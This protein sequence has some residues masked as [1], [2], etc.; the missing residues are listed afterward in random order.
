MIHKI[1]KCRNPLDELIALETVPSVKSKDIDELN[2]SCHNTLVGKV[3][4]I[5]KEEN[6][7]VEKIEDDKAE[8]LVSHSLKIEVMNIPEKS[9]N[10]VEIEV[11]SQVIQIEGKSIDDIRHELEK[12]I[13]GVEEEKE[14]SSDLAPVPPSLDSN[15][16]CPAPPPPPSEVPEPES[17]IEE[18]QSCK[19][20][21]Q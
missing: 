18:C 3:N 7:K 10:D 8:E 19:M 17:E 2:N 1:G 15:N 16:D 9:Q 12:D 21:F 5:V 14:A 13:L 6:L 20:L 11:T 4:D